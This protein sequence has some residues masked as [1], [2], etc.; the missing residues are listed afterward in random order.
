MN[1]QLLSPETVVVLNT[2]ILTA[3]G[4]YTMRPLTLQEA[5]SICMDQTSHT[6]PVCSAIGHESTATI[7]SGLLG[8]HLPVNR[9]EF[10]QV[11]GQRAIVFKLRGRPPEGRI[12][13]REEIEAIGY[14]FFLLRRMTEREERM[15]DQVAWTG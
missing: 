11:P 1:D 2:S 3:P 10:R 9:I 15:V 14:D 7:V 13:T 12:L 8:Q 5:V 4:S 6:Q